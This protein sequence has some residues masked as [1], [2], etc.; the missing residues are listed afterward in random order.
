MFISI[1]QFINEWTHEAEGTLKYLNTLTAD[2][3]DQAIEEDHFSLGELAWHITTAAKGIISQTGLKMD[4]TIQEEMPGTAKEIA[5]TYNKISHAIVEN[6]KIQWNDES[7]KEMKNCFGFDM[8]VFSIL[9][10]TLN[11]QIHH[12]GQMSV[13][14]RQAGLIVPG[15]Y[16]PSREEWA[17]MKK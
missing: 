2:S 12:R 8:P 9:R 16:G 14:M 6:A 11:H 5:E 1:D 13:L 3:L 7:L 17:Q 10:M 15:I 4:V